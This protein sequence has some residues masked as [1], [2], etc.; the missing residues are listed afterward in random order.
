MPDVFLPYQTNLNRQRNDLK[1]RLTDIPALHKYDPDRDLVADQNV[2]GAD[3]NQH[4]NRVVNYNHTSDL[5]LKK[6]FNDRLLKK[7][8]D[9]YYQNEINEHKNPI[10]LP[11]W[12]GGFF[13]QP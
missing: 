12:K 4:T 8:I 6:D 10:Y 7:D 2:L 11:Y 9:Q 1:S 3:G 13:T 5:K